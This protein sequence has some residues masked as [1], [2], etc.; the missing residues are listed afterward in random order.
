MKETGIHVAPGP[1]MQGHAL[2]KAHF[3]IG[4]GIALMAGAFGLDVAAHGAALVALESVAHVAGVL[5]MALTWS[6]VVLDG[7]RNNRRRA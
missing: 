3:V 1:R 2:I 4:P 5:G 7:L 6:A